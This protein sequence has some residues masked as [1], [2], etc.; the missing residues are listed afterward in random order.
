MNGAATPTITYVGEIQGVLTNAPDTLA[1]EKEYNDSFYAQQDSGALPPVFMWQIDVQASIDPETGRMT[2][3][4]LFPRGTNTNNPYLQR[5]NGALNMNFL[6]PAAKW[7][8]QANQ[9]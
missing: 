5:M 6:L 3:K 9:Q 7:E 2:M 8:Q 4:A 1:R